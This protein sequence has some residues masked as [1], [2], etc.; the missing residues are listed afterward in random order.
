ME[1]LADNPLGWRLTSRKHILPQSLTN[2][3][4]TACQ[5]IFSNVKNFDA[6]RVWVKGKLYNKCVDPESVDLI[7]S[8]KQIWITS[9]T[10]F[11]D[12]DD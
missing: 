9:S 2:A 1:E 5:Q 11:K 10:W 8:D 12:E 3:K 4:C 7:L 6:H